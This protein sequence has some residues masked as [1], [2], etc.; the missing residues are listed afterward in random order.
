MGCQKA[1]ANLSK[2][3]VSFEE[4]KTIFN[5]PLLITFPDEGHSET[6]DRLISIGRS[7]INRILLA[8]HTENE[9]EARV[10]EKLFKDGGGLEVQRTTE[11]SI[12]RPRDMQQSVIEHDKRRV[13]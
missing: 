4:A 9:K 1:K 6:E 8:V 5:D 2:H 7:T 10:V 11:T 12:K 3:M 13:A